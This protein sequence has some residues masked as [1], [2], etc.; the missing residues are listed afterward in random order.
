MQVDPERTVVVGASSG[1][2]VAYYAVSSPYSPRAFHV[3][4]LGIIENRDFMLSPSQRRSW[5]STRS[6]ATSSATLTSPS[7]LCVHPSPP[8]LI[9]RSTWHPSPQKPFFQFRCDPLPLLPSGD[10]YAPFLTTSVADTPPTTGTPVDEGAGARGT[11][12]M[13]LMQTGTYLD[14]L[15]GIQGLGA[16][17]GKLEH[18]ERAQAV[19][20]D[21]RALIPSLAVADGN[22]FP[23]TLLVR[24][25]LSLR[26]VSVLI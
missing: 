12:G 20:Q 13:W 17:L 21:A 23:P 11:F 19:P 15:T 9:V 22:A 10:A 25:Y 7:R 16:K 5:E 18:G 3:A 2:A 8:H 14:V 1:G 26:F 6:V 24:A 4:E